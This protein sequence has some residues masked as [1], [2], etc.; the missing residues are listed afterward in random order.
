MIDLDYSNE[1]I[2]EVI[3][4]YVR[5]DRDKEIMK[6]RLCDKLIYAKIAEKMDM[7][8][9]QVKRICYRNQDRIFKNL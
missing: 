4:R 6:Y 1:H 7:S 3:D 8:E 9:S 5:H 2:S